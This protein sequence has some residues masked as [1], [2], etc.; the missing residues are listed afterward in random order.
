MYHETQ[1][2]YFTYGIDNIEHSMDRDIRDALFA[3]GIFV[4]NVAVMI[5]AKMPPEFSAASDDLKIYTC[6]KRMA[7]TLSWA[8]GCGM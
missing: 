4:L 6:T 2:R 5:D 8:V 7:E 1:K 3:R